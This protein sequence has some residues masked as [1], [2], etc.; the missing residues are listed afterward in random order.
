MF[1][2][3][4]IRIVPLIQTEPKAY[5]FILENCIS[6]RVLM[7]ES[8][9]EKHSKWRKRRFKEMKRRERKV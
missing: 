2:S 9:V 5:V 3:A 4:Q 7:M 1:H 6:K 8:M